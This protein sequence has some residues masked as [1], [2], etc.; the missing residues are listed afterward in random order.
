MIL[1][2]IAYEKFTEDYITRINRLFDSKNHLFLVFGQKDYS[3]IKEVKAENVV[4]SVDFASKFKCACFLV[5]NI[6]K[7][8]KVIIHALFLS[9]TYLRLLVIL[10]PFSKKKYFWNIWGYDLYN[11][12][13][14]KNKNSGREKL[15][16]RFIKNL[17]AVGYIHGDYD[18]LLEHYETNAKFYLA[19][20]TYD[21]F[22][23]EA[24]INQKNKETVNILLGKSATEECQYDQAIDFLEQFKDMPIRIKC[25][26]SYPKENRDYRNHVIA[27]G[28]KVFGE[29]FEPLVDFMSFEEYTELLSEIDIAIFNHNRQQALGNIA[30]LLYLGKRIFINPMNSCKNYFED[31]GAKVYSTEDLQISE[32]CK[33][34]C[35]EL[36]KINRKAIDKF[37]SDKEFKERWR[38]I[39]DEKF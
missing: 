23:P 7:A 38:K 19:S 8:K 36:K 24:S 31:I 25:V 9:N 2:L 11:A 20:Y 16:I 3:D 12:Y 1:H 4:Y 13:W 35:T 30:S 22:M 33:K 17:R 29:K 28:K 14:D 6:I 39:F 37:F 5:K 10:Q 21:F 32:I 27:H 26:L 15:R 18:F 34:D